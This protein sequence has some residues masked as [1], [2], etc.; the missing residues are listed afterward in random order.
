MVGYPIPY[1]R[2]N[3][4]TTMCFLN[5]TKSTLSLLLVILKGMRRERKA[6]FEVEGQGKVRVKGY[7]QGFLQI[8]FRKSFL[9]NGYPYLTV[10]P[11]ESLTRP[12]LQSKYGSDTTLS[13]LLILGSAIYMY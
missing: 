6:I 8:V 5:K 12:V 4:H 1:V 2:P 3:L 13:G 9:S 10:I 11:I 7:K